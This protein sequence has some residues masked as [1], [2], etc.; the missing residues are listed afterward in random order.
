MKKLLMTYILACMSV[1][2]VWATDRT[3]DDYVKYQID[4][5]K[6]TITAVQNPDNHCIWTLT[7]VP[8]PGYR[9]AYWQDIFGA[10]FHDNPVNI[11]INLARPSILLSATFVRSNAYV[12]E[13]RVDSVFFASDS[14]DLY[15][16]SERGWAEICIGGTHD[17]NS[18]VNVHK[19]DYGVWRKQTSGRGDQNAYAGVSL[20]YVFFDDCDMPT[21][22]IDTL[23]PIMICGDSIASTINFHTDTTTDVIVFKDASLT[24]DANTVIRGKLDIK[25][26]GKVIVQPGKTLT[27]GGII[28]RSNGFR[29]EYPQLIVGGNVINNY[30]D[31]IFY[32]YSIDAFKYYPLSVPYNV[33]CSKIR[34]RLTNRKAKFSVFDYNTLLRAGGESGWEVYDD[35]APGAELEMG[36]GYIIYAAPYHWKDHAQQ[37]AV[38][39]FPMVAN[40]TSGEPQKTVGITYID[41][42]SVA[43]TN[44]NWNLISNPYLANF[45]V[46]TT[47][48]TTKLVAG[49]WEWDADANR[50][51]L[52]TDEGEVRYITYSTDGFRTY[53]QERL[54]GFT[55]ETFHSYFV[56][57][58]AGNGLTFAVGDRAS[59]V[60]VRRANGVV[61]VQEVEVGITLRQGVETDNAG[62]LYGDYTDEYEINADLTKQFGEEPKLSV[63]SLSGNQPLAYQAVSRELIERAVPIG[64]RGMSESTA[65]FA[66]DDRHYDRSKLAGVWLQ[67]TQTG[68]TVN[69]L[70]DDYSFTPTST[71]DDSRF[72]LSVELLQDPEIE[73]ETGVIGQE[74]DSDIIHIY[75]IMGREMHVAGP[76]APGVYIMIDAAGRSRKEIIR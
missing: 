44:R 39:R 4:N 41:D 25:S 15:S 8:A 71:Q 57:T 65:T 70:D 32:D 20:H 42:A 28:M 61:P 14:T 49:F 36:K 38:V 52:N 59:N 50:Y 68:T 40:L 60:P 17:F 19:L 2:F 45:T 46:G 7:A 9:F 3:C 35:A 11:G 12:Y 48:D 62:M 1:L 22:V 47:S 74:H 76:W 24:I 6:G 51:V 73:I 30:G 27:V 18:D 43:P 5:P 37:R 67:D 34:N 26:G 31:T 23:V 55:M 58:I 21:A 63:Y 72:Y 75:D 53:R 64:Y 69:L 54:K 10:T 13:W 56:Q 33:D 16:G 66:F 29:E